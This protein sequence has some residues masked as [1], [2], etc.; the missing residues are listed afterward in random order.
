MPNKKIYIV[1]YCVKRNDGKAK[2]EMKGGGG[3]GGG[4]TKAEKTGIFPDIFKV[5]HFN[6]QFVQP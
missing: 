4:S 1:C 6:L 2:G 5:K 3:G